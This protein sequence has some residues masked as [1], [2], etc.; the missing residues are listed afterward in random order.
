MRIPYE[1]LSFT[2]S[3]PSAER[4]KKLIR[5]IVEHRNRVAFKLRKS[6]AHT[7]GQ[8]R[9]RERPAR[10]ASARLVLV[11]Y[12]L[13]LGDPTIEQRL[14]DNCRVVLRRHA[15]WTLLGCYDVEA[16]K[17]RANLLDF[18]RLGIEFPLVSGLK[19]SDVECR[20]TVR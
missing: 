2:T 13:N 3:H 4:D 18:L 12:E 14:V 11:L 20:L 10:Y 19:I 1:G 8:L 6:V 16:V 5:E 17:K 9:V 15:G 7:N